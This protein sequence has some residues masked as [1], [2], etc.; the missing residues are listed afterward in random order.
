MSSGVDGDAIGADDSGDL[1]CMA[2][3][4]SPEDIHSLPQAGID[5]SENTPDDSANHNADVCTTDS[6]YTELSEP[7][8]AE[9]SSDFMGSESAAESTPAQDYGP[10]P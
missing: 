1:V 9:V 6:A 3:Q 10:P 4:D 7:A 8:H 2:D 5:H